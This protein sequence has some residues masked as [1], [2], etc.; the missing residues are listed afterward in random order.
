[1]KIVH[2]F[3][4]NLTQGQLGKAKELTRAFLNGSLIIL[5]QHKHYTE[6][7]IRDTSFHLGF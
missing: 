4:S 6:W 2:L 7:Q 5:K 3:R 1:V